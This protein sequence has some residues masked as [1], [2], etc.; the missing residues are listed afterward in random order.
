MKE[1]MKKV[2]ERGRHKKDTA[3]AVGKGGRMEAWNIT[4][5]KRTENE[6]VAPYQF[7]K[8]Y[9]EENISVNISFQLKN[10]DNVHHILQHFSNC[11][12]KFY[13]DMARFIFNNK[14]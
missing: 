9:S 5:K 3:W 7:S 12:H 13:L 10:K 1:K 2:I 14:R 6:V 11:C 4:Q 8:E